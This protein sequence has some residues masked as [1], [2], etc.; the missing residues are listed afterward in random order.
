V[1]SPGGTTMAA[2]GVLEERGFALAV[3]DA[4]SRAA[5]RARE[6]AQEFAGGDG[7]DVKQ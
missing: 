1:T 5:E 7:Q 4:I 2:L 6:L 3:R